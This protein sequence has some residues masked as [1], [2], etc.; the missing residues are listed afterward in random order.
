M[1]TYLPA[2]VAVA[3]IALTYLFCIRPMRRGNACF[4]RTSSG[5]DARG[6]ELERVRAELE[7]LRLRERQRERAEPAG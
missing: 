2:V 1:L 4:T 5:H 7:V 6:L 3:A